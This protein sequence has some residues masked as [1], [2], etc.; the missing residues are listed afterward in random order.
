MFKKPRRLVKITDEEWRPVPNSNDKYQVS[1]Y[2]RIKSFFN[3]GKYE[4]MLKTH[5]LNGFKIA[6]ISI[7]NKKPSI[8][9]HRL[10]AEAWIPKPSNDHN[11]VMH[12]DGNLSN[13][14]ISNL[15]WMTKEQMHAHRR[16]LKKKSTTVKIS[17][18]KLNESDVRLLKSMLQRG[19]SHIQIAKMFC[20]SGMQVTR[21]KRG[22]N[23]GHVQ[24]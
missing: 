2:G 19:V 22:E 14:H 8:Y 6:N 18:S 10:V 20:I 15:A 23:W 3:K 5:E 24:P 1:N 7:N 12:L 11:Y 13:N 16:E 17:N 9:I 4:Q 21:I